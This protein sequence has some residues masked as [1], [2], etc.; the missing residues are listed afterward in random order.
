MSLEPVWVNTF[1]L[2]VQADACQAAFHA[3]LRQ[4]LL[5]LC[6]MRFRKGRV[7]AAC[8]AHF[9]STVAGKWG[10]PTLQ[11]SQASKIVDM[12]QEFFDTNCGRHEFGEVV[13]CGFMFI[14][15]SF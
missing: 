1:V 2:L 8:S 6:T 5:S 10:E 7:C 14:L 9:R 12:C 3:A 4:L 13:G 11:K 15:H